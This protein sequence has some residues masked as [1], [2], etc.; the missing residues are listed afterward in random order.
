MSGASE[1]R[2][3]NQLEQAVQ[4]VSVLAANRNLGLAELLAVL[5]GSDHVMSEARQHRGVR[6]QQLHTL[7]GNMARLEEW[8]DGA[9]LSGLDAIFAQFECVMT[10]GRF[11]FG[12]GD[13]KAFRL[14]YFQSKDTLQDERSRLESETLVVSHAIAELHSPHAFLTSESLS[15]NTGL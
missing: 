10:S 13:R 4:Y 9:G 2:L 11:E 12:L 6:F 5:W 1:Q 8:F 7:Q 3:L 14:T 15:A